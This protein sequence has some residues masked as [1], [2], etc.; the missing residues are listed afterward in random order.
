MSQELEK[1]YDL[2]V[3]S[4]DLT[5][6][7]VAAATARVG[8]KVLHL[9]PFDRYGQEWAALKLFDLLTAPAF[10]F[11]DVPQEQLPPKTSD[12]I[13][14][15]PQALISNVHLNADVFE[16]SQSCLD[17]FRDFSRNISSETIDRF[18]QY[19]YPQMK[20][21]KSA[22]EAREIVAQLKDELPSLNLL[23]NSFSIDITPRVCWIVCIFKL[24]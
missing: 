9:D 13:V 5:S 10:L 8:K 14:C 4:T 15:E 1:H 2:I 7:L 24:V 12:T 19:Y 20:A 16:D 23:D 18:S 22:R 17:F 6:S 21:C 11:K 3:T